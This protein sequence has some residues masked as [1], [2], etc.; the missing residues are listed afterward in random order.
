MM[1]NKKNSDPLLD[2]EYG[3]FLT[4]AIIDTI[5][6]PLIIL[7][8]KLVVITAG[9]SFYEKFGL[10]FKSTHDK[11]FYDLGEGEWN[12]GAL[13]EQLENVIIHHGF[14]ENFEVVHKFNKLGERIMLVS[15]REIVYERRLKRMLISIRDITEQ[16]NL[17]HQKE[18]L[19]KQKDI[20]IKEMRHRIANSLQII[21]SILLLKAQEVTSEET[22]A[23]LEDVHDR[24][25][26]IATVQGHLDPGGLSGDTNLNAYLTE[27]C[28]GLA[29]SMI[30]NRRPLTIKVNVDEGKATTDEAI[31]IGL[32][33]TELVINSI[34]H[35]FNP[36]EKGEI[37]VSYESNGPNWKLSVKD[38][39]SGISDDK[40]KN[41]KGLGSGIVD[42]LVKQLNA[43]IKTQSNSGGTIVS[44]MHGLKS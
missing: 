34:K 13:R 44:I 36:N 10:D 24:I 38:N 41:R 7:D 3:H 27:L 43:T 22:R 6:E 8:E 17:E 21:A 18:Q 42:T 1:S 26:S 31:G 16:R 4:R 35:A 30:G 39:G 5:E 28:K 29:R 12:I 40:L 25:M 15:A 20:L 33:T 2:L 23:Q 9:R 11:K 14:V 19:S 37:I 32:I